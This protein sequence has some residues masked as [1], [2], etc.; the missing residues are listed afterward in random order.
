[1]MTLGCGDRLDRV[2]SGQRMASP[3]SK[4][5]LPSLQVTSAPSR[6]QACASAGPAQPMAIAEMRNRE[7]Q[8]PIDGHAA[9]RPLGCRTSQSSSVT[10]FR[11][12]GPK[13]RKPGADGN[14]KL[15]RLFNY[16]RKSPR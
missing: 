13:M 7:H 2:P 12:N 6:V 9:L 15:P 4:P 14:V 8:R 3:D 11:F 16:L 1:M 10:D 5:R